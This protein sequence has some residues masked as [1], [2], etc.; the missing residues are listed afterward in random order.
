M[1]SPHEWDPHNVKFNNHARSFEE[2][3]TKNYSMSAL[4]HHNVHEICNNDRN[5][6]DIAQINH[7]IINSVKVN[8][9]SSLHINKQIQAT[10]TKSHV[11]IN[12]PTSTAKTEMKT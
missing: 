2:D 9:P 11:P 10:V 7:R 6:F 5:L 4:N 8:L 12:N 3:T 1:N